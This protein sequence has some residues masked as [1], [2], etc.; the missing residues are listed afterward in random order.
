MTWA[1]SSARAASTADPKVPSHNRLT[2]LG[3]RISATHLPHVRCFTTRVLRN[4]DL[5]H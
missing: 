3:S 1:T 2:L 4:L 5:F